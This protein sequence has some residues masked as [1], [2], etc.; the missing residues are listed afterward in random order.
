MPPPLFQRIRSVRP[1]DLAQIAAVALRLVRAEYVLRRRTVEA[2]ARSFSMSF[3]QPQGATTDGDRAGEST[4]FTAHEHR[5]LINASRVLRRWPLDRSCLRRSLV[6]GWI[7]RD[8]SPALM[9]GTRADGDTIHAHAWV[10]VGATD[11]D[12]TAAQHAVFH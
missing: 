12:T 1:V 10:R 2:A 5:W 3:G 4:Q 7:L 8:R 9:I 11:L 6:I